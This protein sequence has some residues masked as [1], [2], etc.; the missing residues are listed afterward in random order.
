[1]NE[2]IAGLGAGA[3]GWAVPG[4]RFDFVCECGRIGGCEGRVLMTLEE[5]ERVRSQRDRFA[6]VP[7]HQT[8][9]I[10]YVVEQDATY[11]IVDK[12]DSVEPFVE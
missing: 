4:E 12:R 11:V 10:E 2:Q 7:G 8:D 6:L 1:M 3:A 5:Y 9:E